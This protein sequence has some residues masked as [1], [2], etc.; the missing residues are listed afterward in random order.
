MKLVT[1]EDYKRMRAWIYRYASYNYLTTFRYFMEGGSQ[2]EVVRALSFY[3]N[4]DGGFMSFDPDCWNPNSS[5]LGTLTAFDT[6]RSIGITDKNHPMIQEMIQYIEKCDYCTEKGCYWSIPSNN[7]YPSQS[8]F[9]YPHAPWHPDDWPA[10][11]YINGKYVDFV[12]A[13][14]DQDTQMYQK[15]RKVITYR[16]TFMDR[17]SEFCSFTSEIEQNI[18]AEDWLRFIG[19]LERHGAKSKA[20]CSELK[21]KLKRILKQYGNQNVYHYIEKQMKVEEA[22]INTGRI[23]DDILDE[24]V[25]EIT[26]NRLWSKDGLVCDKPEEKIDEMT[27]VYTLLWPIVE[28]IEKLEKL[29]RF[30]R[31]ELLP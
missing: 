2:E 28:L 29:K 27:R 20:E 21:D 5:P 14:F 23:P 25:D 8:Y 4:E 13:Y 31:I 6:L 9:L 24:M 17:L 19:A 11:G 10:E 30:N 7:Q 16:I 18:E 26:I 1:V 12:L 15:I 22:V 3:Q